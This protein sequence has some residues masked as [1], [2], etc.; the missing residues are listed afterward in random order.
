MSVIKKFVKSDRELVKSCFLGK[1]VTT[2]DIVCYYEST[3]LHLSKEDG[4]RL[5]QYLNDGRTLTINTNYYSDRKD[6]KNKTINYRTIIN[7]V[8]LTQ[9]GLKDHGKKV[10]RYK[11]NKDREVWNE[12]IT[13][14][15]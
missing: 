3:Y 6:K 11:I 4:D 2:R 7:V 10:Y 12:N 5:I 1:I 8:S 14:I 13:F 15:K 9:Y